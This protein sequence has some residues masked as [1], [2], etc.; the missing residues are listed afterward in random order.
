MGSESSPRAAVRPSAVKIEVTAS[1]VLPL[2]HN[3]RRWRVTISRSVFS[4]GGP[5][6]G[7]HDETKAELRDP[8]TVADYT[9]YEK[10]CRRAHQA[11][12]DASDVGLEA[13]SREVASTAMRL[14]PAREDSI[15]TVSTAAGTRPVPSIDDYRD[16]LRRFLGL[17]RH[18]RARHV[19]IYICEGMAADGQVDAD[20]SS[21]HSLLWELLEHETSEQTVEVHRL[22]TG[23]RNLTALSR[24]LSDPV[25]QLRILL[26]VARSLQQHEVRS[27]YLDTESVVYDA[28]SRLTRYL[29]GCG[30]RD[31]LHVDVVSVGGFDDFSSQL[32]T[33]GSYDIVHFD[34]HGVVEEYVLAAAPDTL[35]ALIEQTLTT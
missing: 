10:W 26:V 13:L 3:K 24:G 12:E 5:P 11:A 25:G 22:F 7:K 20:H 4:S 35:H 29:K 18:A 33:G 1:R 9:N 32:R 30:H 23:L 17:S 28:L 15:G 19:K 6:R 16:E 31:R 14:P 2:A 34:M 8:F 21:I 27:G